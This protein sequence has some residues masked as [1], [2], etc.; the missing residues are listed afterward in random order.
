MIN[1]KNQG[2]TRARNAG[3]E[4][5]TGDYIAF[6]DADDMWHP[7]KLEKILNVINSNPTVDIVYHNELVRSIKGQIKLLKYGKIKGDSFRNVLFKGN[8]LS[9]SATVVRRSIALKTGG[10]SKI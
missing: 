7:T 1:Q 3:I 8:K 2:Q 10:F 4:K 6:L 9:T 5:A